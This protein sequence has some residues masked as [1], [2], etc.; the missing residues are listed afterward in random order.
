MLVY[1]R[2]VLLNKDFQVAMAPLNMFLDLCF[3]GP[4]EY[5]L[6]LCFNGPF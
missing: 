1:Q 3:N 2:V 5:V 4:L 6:D